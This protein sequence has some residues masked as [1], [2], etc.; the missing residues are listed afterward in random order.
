MKVA[1]IGSSGYIASYLIERLTKL[2]DIELLLKVGRGQDSDGV[3][4]LARAEEFDYSVLGQIDYVIFTAAISGPDKCANEYEECWK[5]NVEGTQFFI[6]KALDMGCRVL[7]FSSDAV[8]GDIPGYVYS[9]MSETKAE[10]PYGK[11]K[12]AIEDVFANDKSFKAIRLSYVVSAKDKFTSYCLKCIDTNEKAEIFHPFYRSCVMLSEVGRIVIW[13]MQHW[14]EFPH[15][16]LNACGEELVSR[17]RMADELNRVANDRLEYDIVS[18]S[19]EFYRNRPRYTQ[20]ASLYLYDIL[21]R[22]SF[23]ERFQKEL[24]GYTHAK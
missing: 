16:F 14:K 10:T 9:E 22:K 13:L 20:M 24:E 12:K 1:I 17:V 3:L 4:D 15:T 2:K 5:I 18:P 11:M 21:E 23:T 8:Y 19:A 6:R 7:F